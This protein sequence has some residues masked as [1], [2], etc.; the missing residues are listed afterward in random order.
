[1]TTHSYDCRES[2]LSFE[3]LRAFCSSSNRLVKATVSISCFV[4]PA[5]RLLQHAGSDDRRE[6]KLFESA[7]CESRSTCLQC[8]I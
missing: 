7:C 4:P 6:T 8:A 3:H 2:D 1:M 5:G